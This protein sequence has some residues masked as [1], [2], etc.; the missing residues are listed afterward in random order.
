MK[1]IDLSTW[2]RKAHFEFF[3]QFEEPYFGT[4]VSVD[5]TKAYK[6]AKKNNFSFFTYYLH[7]CVLATNTVENFKYRI[8]PENQVVIHDTIGASATMMR[9]DETFGFSYIP[10][11]ESFEAFSQVT[12]QE[13]DRIQN[14]QDLFPPQNP[15]N[16]IH[17]S[18][19]PWLNFTALTHARFYAVKDSVPKISFS[20]VTEARGIK[21]MN[22]SVFVHHALVDGLHV[23][24]FFDVFQEVLNE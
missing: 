19:I 12:Q 10:Y 9:T 3:T 16:V 20:K 1:T 6:I 11:L 5:V 4:V 22:V 14:S 24:R 18:A 2:K 23:A 8:T 7:K 21:T 17:Y 15:D 13:R